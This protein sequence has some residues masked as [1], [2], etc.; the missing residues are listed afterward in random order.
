MKN[1]N[2]NIQN[3]N[4]N[5]RILSHEGNVIE[6]EVNGTSYSVKM[7]EETK[8]AKTPKLVRAASKRPAEPLKVNPSSSSTKIV[9]PIPGVVLSIDVKVGDTIKL[10][11]RLLV[12]EAMKMENNIASEKAGTVTAV[13]VTVGQQVLQNEVMIELE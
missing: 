2:F 8:K 6:M 12:L 4:Y 9:A 13:K 11:D 10:G 1:F 7:K 5:V 3:N